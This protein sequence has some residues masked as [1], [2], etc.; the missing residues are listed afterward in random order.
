MLQRE[1][2]I[3]LDLKRVTRCFLGRGCRWLQ[4]TEDVGWGRVARNL[5]VMLRGLLYLYAMKDLNGQNEMIR[6]HFRK[7]TVAEFLDMDKTRDKETK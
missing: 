6:L 2:G 7:I 5:F 3:K 4:V 1:D